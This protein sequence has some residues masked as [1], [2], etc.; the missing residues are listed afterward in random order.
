MAGKRSTGSHGRTGGLISG[1]SRARNALANAPRVTVVAPRRKLLP[2]RE[3]VEAVAK[4]AKKQKVQDKVD[5]MIRKRK[6]DEVWQEH[7]ERTC[8]LG[9]GLTRQDTD[10]ELTLRSVLLDTLNI[11]RG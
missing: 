4:K 9:S 3:V 5:A 11:T 8:D 7:L 6:R 1:G 10:R 2:S